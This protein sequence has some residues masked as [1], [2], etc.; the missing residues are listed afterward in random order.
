[1]AMVFWQEREKEFG[2]CILRK[3]GKTD[4]GA[5]SPIDGRYVA[6]GE[7]DSSVTLFQTADKRGDGCCC[8]FYRIITTFQCMDERF[9]VVENDQGTGARSSLQNSLLQCGSGLILPVYWINAIE[10]GQ[11]V[12]ETLGKGLAHSDA[13]LAIEGGEGLEGVGQHAITVVPADAIGENVGQSSLT[14]ATKPV[15]EHKA[16]CSRG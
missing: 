15:Q 8:G 13:V 1:M 9:Q 16:A 11:T 14:D 6:R 4:D 5:I 2:S 10:A 12:V 7:Q 3:T